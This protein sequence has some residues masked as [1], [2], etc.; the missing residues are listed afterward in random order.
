[1]LKSHSRIISY[2][3]S[4]IGISSDGIA[5]LWKA[6]STEINANAKIGSEETSQRMS[7]LVASIAKYDSKLN[8]NARIGSG[9]TSRRMSRVIASIA[10]HDIKVE[11]KSQDLI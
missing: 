2:S 1:M 4:A 9:E 10:K 7:R 3:R 8:A 6:L 11:R 5:R